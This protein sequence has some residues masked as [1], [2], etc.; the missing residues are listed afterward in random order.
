MRVQLDPLLAGD[1]ASLGNHMLE[2]LVS[3]CLLG[4]HLFPGPVQGLE[5]MT[6]RH[7]TGHWLPSSSSATGV[8]IETM[9]LREAHQTGGSELI[10][11]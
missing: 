10:A 1:L 8:V 9:N 6:P 2:F 11:H 3:E 4:D 5:G 7:L